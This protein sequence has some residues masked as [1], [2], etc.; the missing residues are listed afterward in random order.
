[1]LNEVGSGA[2]FS[3]YVKMSLMDTWLM[4]VRRIGHNPYGLILAESFFSHCGTPLYFS[5][6]AGHGFDVQYAS[7]ASYPTRASLNLGIEDEGNYVSLTIIPH[8]EVEQFMGGDWSKD[9][10]DVT[11][12]TAD[13]NDLKLVKQPHLEGPI[14]SSN[15]GPGAPDARINNVKDRTWLLEL[16]GNINEGVYSYLAKTL[17]RT[18]KF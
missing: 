6:K 8:I 14:T 11:F 17:N 3:G 1:M 18:G 12:Y 10:S 15:F 4:D 16:M 13:R 2:D 7:G 9:G 5:I